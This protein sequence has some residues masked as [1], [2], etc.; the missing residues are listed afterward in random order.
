VQSGVVGSGSQAAQINRIGG[1][2]TRWAIPVFGWPSQP[3]VV[4]DWDM[5]VQNSNGGAAFGPFFGSEA[6]DVDAVV[7]G[8]GLLGS[9]GVDATTRE[10]LYQDAGTGFL[11]P[12]GALV[13]FDQWHHFRMI[14]DYTFN[15]YT[16]WLD[17]VMVGPMIGFVD[18]PGLDQFTDADISA[19]AAAGD[20]ASRAL[21]GVA[22]F[23]NFMVRQFPNKASIP[24]ADLVPEPSSAA[25]GALVLAALGSV[26]R[27][28]RNRQK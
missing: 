12:T 13:N 15:S 21:G 7:G 4:I 3:C 10:V 17:N 28:L 1:E 9:L 5:R 19:I 18:G 16:V 27:R 14:L 6:Y 20:P 23:D 24:P 11:T 26:G 25:L 22:Y 8:N 2:D